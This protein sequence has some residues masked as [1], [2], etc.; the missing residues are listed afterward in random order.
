MALEEAPAAVADT[1]VVGMPAERHTLRV[2]RAVESE[3]AA[4][5]AVLADIAKANKGLCLWP[6][7]EKV[8]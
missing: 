8:A 2:L 3:I 4:H 5:E 1:E 6:P 7:K